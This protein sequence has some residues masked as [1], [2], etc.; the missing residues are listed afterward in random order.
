MLSIQA[1]W[2]RLLK[3]SAPAGKGNS[4]SI[5]APAVTSFCFTISC[6]Q[7]AFLQARLTHIIVHRLIGEDYTCRLATSELFFLDEVIGN[8]DSLD[9][10]GDVNLVLNSFQ[11]SCLQQFIAE[12]KQWFYERPRIG[13]EGMGN[14]EVCWLLDMINIAIKVGIWLVSYDRLYVL[15]KKRVKG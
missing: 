11:L 6:N 3:S 5:P 8:D 2:P 1:M 12:Q 13:Y 10:T 14:A 4:V 7:W 15:F 9:T